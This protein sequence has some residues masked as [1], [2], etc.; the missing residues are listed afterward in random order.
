MA[1]SAIEGNTPAT[2][3]REV[4]EVFDPTL[5]IDPATSTFYVEHEAPMLSSLRKQLKWA[6]EPMKAFLCGHRG[7]GKTTQL[8]RLRSDAEL[9]QRYLTIF[10]NASEL[11]P[12]L[13]DL[14]H[15]ALLVEISRAMLDHGREHGIDPV[16]GAELEQWGRQVVK[17]FLHDESVAAEVGAKANAWLAFFKAQLRS[18]R[19]WRSEQRQILEPR[20]QDLVD[21][22]NRMAQD[23]Y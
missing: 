20:V 18:R 22:V 3:L 13:V 19:E 9:R 1:V 17:T 14:S 5:A 10:I 12:D 21:L 23:L 8:Q 7:S 6:R 15:D 2:N 11:S 16:F 4:W